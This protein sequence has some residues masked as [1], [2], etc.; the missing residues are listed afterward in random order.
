MMGRLFSRKANKTEEDKSTDGSED[1]VN[2]EF[3]HEPQGPPPTFAPNAPNDFHPSV[4]QSKITEVSNETSTVVADPIHPTKAIN[5]ASIPPPARQSAFSG[6]PRFDWI[7][8]VRIAM[9]LD[10]KSH[11]TKTRQQVLLAVALLD[12]V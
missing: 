5:P 11:K 3:S 9:E 1:E 4:I 10:R 7:D 12:V 8:I 2:D 6:P